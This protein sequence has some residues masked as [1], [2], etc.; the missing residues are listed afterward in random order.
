MNNLKTIRSEA[1]TTLIETLVSL[2]LFGFV[3]IIA[4]VLLNAVILN[5]KIVLRQEAARIAFQEIDSAAKMRLKTDTSYSST[6]KRFEIRRNVILEGKIAKATITVLTN[7]N[8][9]SLIVL[10]NYYSTE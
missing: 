1:G 6:D 3:L 8:R 4:I 7:Y 2:S 9:D 5:P 10:H